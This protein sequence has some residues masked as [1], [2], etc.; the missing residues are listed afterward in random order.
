[1]YV[2]CILGSIM[3]SIITVHYIA[4]LYHFICEH[5]TRLLVVTAY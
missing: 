5:L 4:D 3:Y 2:Y 1:M